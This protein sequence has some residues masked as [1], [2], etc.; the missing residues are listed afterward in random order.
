MKASRLH[1]LSLA[2]ICMAGCVASSL[3]PVGTTA[4]HPLPAEADVTV[5]S[6][7]SDIHEPFEVV[8]IIDYANPGKYQLLTLADA[9]PTLLDKAR[10]A[11]A[12]GIIIDRLDSIRSGLISTGIAVRARAVR[13]ADPAAPL[14]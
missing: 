2:A 7:D 14:P 9:L 10:S 4:Y 13:L 1:V 6:A 3:T 5:F 11:G 8:G 12:N